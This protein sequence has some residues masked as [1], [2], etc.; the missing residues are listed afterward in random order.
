M[1]DEDEDANLYYYNSATSTVGLQ[2]GL[3]SSTKWAAIAGDKRWA[4]KAPAR[5]E[6][7]LVMRPVRFWLGMLALVGV[8]AAAGPIQ[9]AGVA[10]SV[11]GDILSYQTDPLAGA[12]SMSAFV[13]RDGPT[14]LFSDDP[15]T[16]PA[17]GILYQ[18]N[19]SGPFR[20]FFDHVNGQTTGTMVF[21]VLVTN[22]GQQPVQLTLDRVGVAGPSGYVL[23]NGQAAEHAWMGSTG[24]GTVTVAPG[25]TAFLD[26]GLNTR[27]AGPQ[28]NVTGILDATASG[29]VL[30]SVVAE[31]QPVADITGLQVLRGV[32]STTGFVM[33][34]TFP[35]ADF[36]L[37]AQGNGSMQ[38][39]QIATPMDYLTG[40]SAVDDLPTEDYGNYGVLYDMH[41]T[42]MTG[43][44]ERL[45][46]IFDP[47]G[48]TF[49]GSALLGTGYLPGQVLDMPAG[50]SFAPSPT[51]GILLARYDLAAD[52]PL[53]MHLQW[54][55]PSGSSLPASLLL[56]AY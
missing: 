43:Q 14:L 15:E 1:T 7:Y 27:P 24:G 25:Q 29:N 28:D 10:Q 11:P 46:A 39:L 31:A 40:F 23:L 53:N 36:T 35:R 48:G 3:P 34:G 9:A 19:V 50:G 37:A 44:H 49:S 47:R 55:P 8:V 5:V 33:R 38:Y 54:M 51:A 21:T 56:E 22:H 16:V 26:P 12:Q 41:V 32:T 45:A 20:V 17:P 4:Q 42:V 6:G 13:Q 52:A 2:E 18:D 30:V